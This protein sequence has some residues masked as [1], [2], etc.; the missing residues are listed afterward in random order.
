MTEYLDA[1][2]PEAAAL[3]A[4]TT[5]VREGETL[6]GYNT[7][8]QGVV[9]ALK[10]RL[11]DPSGARCTVIG[12]G[13]AGRAAA[14]GLVMAGFEVTLLNRSEEKARKAAERL[15]CAWE[16]W[17][18]METLLGMTDI[19][20]SAVSSAEA[21]IPETA[22]DPGTVVLE[23]D[24]RT[25]PLKAP[26]RRRRCLYIGGEEWLLHQAL[27]AFTLFTGM[28]GVEESMW[29]ALMQVLSRG[30]RRSN[31][32]LIGF[33]GCG[34]SSVGR[35]LAKK[36]KSPFVDTDEMIENEEGVSIPEI[37]RRG[38][39][40]RFRD[41]ETQ[42]VACVTRKSGLVLSC[43]GGCI[44]DRRNRRVLSE[45]SLT[46]WLWAPL[47]VCLQRVTAGSRPLLAGS[48][49]RKRAAGLLERRIPLY[50]G[51]ADLVISTAGK[52]E[53]AVEALYEEIGST[54]DP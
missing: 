45:Q 16:S 3:G 10:T 9:Q 18:G 2:D 50:G 6:K 43:G 36:I 28:E 4:V 25:T 46:V 13:A 37:F 21:V 35:Q 26:A 19:L 38:G 40:R 11:H 24:Y 22:L 44:E 15:N 8:P 1:L 12:V 34:K 5:V 32:A 51:C 39:E 14:Y 49:P 48:D 23:A 33:M 41:L 31:L 7:D 27:P 47:S 20:V 17:D 42:T 30:A 54:L 52:L 53:E 29:R